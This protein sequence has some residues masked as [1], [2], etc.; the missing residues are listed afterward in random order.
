MTIGEAIK[1]VDR[2]KPNQFTTAQ[3]VGWLSDCDSNIY[4][5]IVETHE[6]PD[7]MPD[8]F[9]G[10]A[11]DD[12][13]GRLLAPPPYDVMYKYFL[14]AQIDL[15]NKELNNYNNTSKLFNSAHEEFENWYNKRYMPRARVTHFKL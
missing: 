7:F 5:K 9:V 4:R 2:L 15:Y 1:L 8:E 10:Y 14:E 3:K 13:D 12:L 6:K 11:L